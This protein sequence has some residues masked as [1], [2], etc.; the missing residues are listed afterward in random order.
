M[1]ILT[2]SEIE[3][4][5]AVA[6]HGTLTRA[7]QAVYISQPALTKRINSLEDGLGFR[8]VDRQRGGRTVTLTEKGKE[9]IAIAVRY[10]ELLSD[11]EALRGQS[12]RKRIT[13]Y[14]S[15]GPHLFVLSSLYNA[16]LKEFPG[17][18][19]KLCTASYSE[20][21]EQVQKRNADLAFTGV[22]F[23]YKDITTLPAYSEQMHF[24][25]RRDSSY[26]EVIHPSQLLAENAI[27]SPYSSEYAN[28]YKYWFRRL[29]T[30]LTE[31]HLVSQVEKFMTALH[32]DVWTVAPASVMLELVKN[33]L[34]TTR[35][36][37]E[38]PSDRV[39]YYAKRSD[40]E[41]SHIDFF[42]HA[43]KEKTSHMDDIKCLLAGSAPGEEA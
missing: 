27:Y 4:F 30:P 18:S 40:T 43:L 32:E 13:I 28:W 10:R 11:S 1:R 29:R 8:L 7:A 2:Y 41:S 9:F 39:I 22:N 20:C 34:L 35:V 12:Y 25:C 31:V 17:L 33:P 23:Y 16:F 6:Q 3:A 24:I 37:R 14:S 36:L 21:F 42:L 26:A 19:L 5:L 38:P 15:D